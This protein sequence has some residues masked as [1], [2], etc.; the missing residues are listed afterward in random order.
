MSDLA[1]M[2][3]GAEGIVVAGHLLMITLG[4]TRS[5]RV[6]VR[7][8]GDRFELLG[9]V[10]RPGVL[11]KYPLPGGPERTS[12]RRNRSTLLVGFRI[13]HKGRLVGEAWVPK[14][15]LTPDEFCFYVRR[16]AAECDRFEF[17]ITGRDV[18]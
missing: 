9:V 5:H 7:D 4:D 8:A 11:E 15:G 14:A 16:L 1:T 2:C 10:A 18:E 17:R 3:K 6:K 12:W 13:D